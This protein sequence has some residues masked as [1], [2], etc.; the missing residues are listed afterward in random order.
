LK[1]IFHKKTIL[2][3]HGGYYLMNEPRQKYLNF[4]LN[5]IFKHADS[6]LV[7]STLEK[8]ILE[9]R[10][11]AL[12]FNVFPNAVNITSSP[13]NKKERKEVVKFV[14]MGRI[15]RSK[16]IY[17][18][19][20]SFKYLSRHFDKFVFNIYGAGPDLDDWLNAL[21]SLKGL[22][23]NYNGIVG[24]MEKWKILNSADVF[25]LPSLHSEGLPMA[26]IEAMAAGCAVVVTDVASIK[27]V[28]NNSNGILLNE[29]S[30]ELL[31]EKI[32]EILENKI[33][34]NAIGRQAKEFV[35]SNL[36]FSNYI[37]NLDSLYAA[38]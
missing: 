6:I 1:N 5:N 8:D 33:D 30:P 13:E 7:L 11:G 18:I 12:N 2:H 17:T 20:E 36:S 28:V 24:D 34:V 38:L 37:R 25:L 22:Q 10:Y 3:V 23:F 32:E 27:T 9:K 4:L 21:K 26:M 14:F 19:S 31:A 16:G 29:S 35:R 15:N